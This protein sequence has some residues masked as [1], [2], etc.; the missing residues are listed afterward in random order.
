MNALVR[1]LPSAARRFVA[2]A[3]V[4]AGALSISA[5]L[6]AEERGESG[7]EEREPPGGDR[8]HLYLLV[9]QSNMAGRGAVTEEDRRPDPRIWMFDREGNWS[10]AVDPLHFDKPIAGVG[11]GRSFARAM[12]GE[13]SN[14]HIGL[15]P[16]AVGGS[17]IDAWESGGFHEQTGAHPWDDMAER[18]EQSL[19]RGGELR[20]ILWHQGESDS[21]EESAPDYEEKL[22]SLVDR[23]RE[24]AS[25]PEVPFIAGGMGR[26]PERPWNKW[27]VEV[28]AAHRALPGKVANAAYVSSDGLDH[29]DEVH[30]DRASYLE[31]GRRYAEAMKALRRNAS[32]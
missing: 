11:L 19:R 13:D 8:F 32:E 4:V 31:L 26:W 18:L 23:F 7:K 3:V 20:G 1:P 30:F 16:C 27:K 14:V 9:G 10:P 12:L 15:I 22:H 2:I 6:F 29:R 24:L 21:N 5:G 28:D 25:A 17:P